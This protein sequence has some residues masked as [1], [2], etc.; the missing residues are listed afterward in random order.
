M[1]TMFVGIMHM[2]KNH[3][4]VITDRLEEGIPRVVEDHG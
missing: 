4:Q 1:C 3:D 2:E